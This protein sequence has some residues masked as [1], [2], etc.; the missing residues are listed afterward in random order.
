MYWYQVHN[1]KTESKNIII[2]KKANHHFQY[3]LMS[4]LW[5]ISFNPPSNPYGLRV[6]LLCPF[7]WTKEWVRHHPLVHCLVCSLIS[8]VHLPRGCW[9]QDLESGC[10]IPIDPSLSFPTVILELWNPWSLRYQP[11]MQASPSPSLFSWWLCV[12]LNFL[13]HR[14]QPVNTCI[15]ELLIPFCLCP[16]FIRLLCPSAVRGAWAPA[17]NQGSPAALLSGC[18]LATQSVAQRPATH[19]S[20]GAAEKYRHSALPQPCGTGSMFQ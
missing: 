14:W 20:S 5:I 16:L 3:H 2:P 13:V 15:Q 8:W 4:S 1:F 7:R 6:R 12:D 11:H 17:V 18:T 19:A 9:R 10:Q